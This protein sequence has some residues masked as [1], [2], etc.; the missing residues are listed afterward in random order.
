MFAASSL[1]VACD[2]AESCPSHPC[3][4][5]SNGEPFDLLDWC[6][7]TGGCLLDDAPVCKDGDRTPACV[8]KSVDASETLTFPVGKLW[9]TLGGRHDLVVTYASCDQDARPAD[10]TDLQVR[11]DGKPAQ[12]ASMDPCDPTGTPTVM[13]CLGI[14]S[15]VSSITF[16][17]TY[18]G[19]EG[20]TSLQVELQD[21]TCSY[22][23]S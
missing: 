15:T 23:C 22:F 9:P 13:T 14:P 6:A 12:C 20:P 16:S 7:E 17:F 1:A 21:T 19:A 3:D 18:G 10:F 5:T 2:G 4:P 8:L 11:F